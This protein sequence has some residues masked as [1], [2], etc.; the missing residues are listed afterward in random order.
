MA[1]EIRWSVRADQD[2]IEIFKYWNKRNKSV[3]YSIKLNKLF[4]A[5]LEKLANQPGLGREVDY[6][7]LRKIVVTNYLIYY[8][9][10]S[11]YIKVLTIWDSRR[12]P[13][14]FKL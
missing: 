6:P 4:I 1:K 2:R 13:Q 14:K 5:S 12:D 9:I 3:S 8:E 10:S 11:D 7:Y